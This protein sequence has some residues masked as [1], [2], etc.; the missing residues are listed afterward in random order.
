MAK[1]KINVEN[2]IYDAKQLGVPKT[3]LLGVQHLFAMFGATV[4]VPI[5]T[6]LSVSSTLLFA[7]IGTLLFH[8][9]TKGRIP[10]FLGSSFAF[11]GGYFAVNA[12]AEQYGVSDP[13]TLLPYAC[14]GVAFAGLVYLLMSGLI[15]IFGAKKIMRFFPPIVTGPIIIAIGLTLSGSAITN[16]QSN[17]L[18]AIVAIAIIVICNVFGKGMIKIIPI[19]LG[20]V[21]SCIFAVIYT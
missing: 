21:G 4:L 19:I 5:L 13:K 11:L 6:G 17:W 9:L 20:V 14:L 12:W 3:L 1:N 7:G 10:A 2:G 15:K 8:L 16:C 18:I